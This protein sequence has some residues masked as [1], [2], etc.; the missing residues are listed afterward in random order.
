MATLHDT[1]LGSDSASGTVL[2]TTDALAVTA[3]DL[4]VLFAKAEGASTTITGS[5][6]QG[7]TYSV[8]NSLL[9]HP[10]GDL[11]GACLW[12]VAGSTGTVNPTATYGASRPFREVKA[13]SFTLGGGKS[14][15]ALDAVNAATGT[16]NTP[17]AGAAS[18]TTSGAAAVG[19][20]LYGT[21]SLTIGS[22]WT[23]PLEFSSASPQVSEYQ[24]QA[25][26]GS[27][28]GNGTLSTSVEWVAQLAIF[29]ETTG[30]GVVVQGIIPRNSGPGINPGTIKFT[31]PPRAVVI[32]TSVSVTLTGSSGTFAQGTLT[33]AIAQ[34]LTGNSSAVSTGTLTSAVV[35]TLSGSAVTLSQGVVAPGGQAA[36]TGTAVTVS[37]GTLTSAVIQTISGIAVS[38]STGNLN[39]LTVPYGVMKTPGPGLAGPFNNGQFIGAPRGITVSSP[40]VSVSISGS[41]ITSSLGTLTSA[42]VE[43]LTGQTSTFA[44]GTVTVGSNVTVSI[45]GTTVTV[46]IGTA[47]SSITESITGN[48]ITSS[49]GTLVQA[50]SQSLVGSVITISTGTVS[51]SGGTTAATIT[52]KAG[53]WLRYKAI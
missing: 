42:I 40:N 10:N 30:S 4:I 20:H 35:Q 28:T 47:V 17:S 34:A 31:N 41:A 24:L 14:G 37:L 29:K 53:S 44:Q 7:N 45:T 32:N 11:S 46:S 50:V 5:D 23:I 43:T 48:L 13:Y 38:V 22:G 25:G 19:F 12:A 2:A 39:V 33:S 1:A 6:G 3:G 8:A 26:A 51:P 16:S 9:E 27:L 18:A 52:I 15:W 49:T 21:R 36:I